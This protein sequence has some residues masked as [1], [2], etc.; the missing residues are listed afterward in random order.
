MACSYPRPSATLTPHC[1]GMGRPGRE[2]V[3]GEGEIGDFSKRK[4]GSPP[5]LSSPIQG[6]E[7]LPAYSYRLRAG[8]IIPRGPPP[9]IPER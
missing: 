1:G 6:E 8:L 3:A 5:P 9:A 7:V 2:G 4:S